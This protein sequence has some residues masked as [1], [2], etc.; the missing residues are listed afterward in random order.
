MHKEIQYI[1]SQ[2]ALLEHHHHSKKTPSENIKLMMAEIPLA[3]SVASAACWLTVV[4][5]WGDCIKP[6]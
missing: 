1:M 5:Y 2:L 6:R 4:A 3:A